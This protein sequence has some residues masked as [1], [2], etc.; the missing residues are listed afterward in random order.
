MS[1][2]NPNRI[3]VTVRDVVLLL[4]SILALASCTE[5]GPTAP[6]VDPVSIE[7]GTL[8]EAIEGRAY[9]QQL[10]A[11]GGGG[12]YDWVVAAGSLPSGLTLSPAGLISGTPVGAGTSSFRVRATDSSGLSATKE[13]AILLVQALA[14]HTWALPDAMEDA[15]YAAQIQ[16]VGGR[17]TLTWSL[18][19]EAAAWLMVSATGSLSGVP[20]AA[21]ASAVTIT[22][23]DESGQQAIRELPILIRGPLAVAAITLPGATEGRAYAAQLVATGGDGAYTWSVESGVLPTGVGLTTGGALTGTPEEGGEFTFTAKVTD[24]A[25]RVATRP[26]SLTVERAPLIQTTLLAPGDVGEPYAAQLV[27]VGGTGAYTWSVT[28]GALPAGLTLSTSG[29]ITGTPTALGSTTFTIRVTDGTGATHT[30]PFTF[31]VAR[32]QELASGVALVG[33]GGEAGSVR[34]YAIRV[35][36]GATRLTVA[37]S[38][39]TGDA[40]LYIR[41]GALPLQFTYDCRPLRQGNEETCTITSPTEGYWYVMLRGHEDF[42]GLSLLA[43]VD[44]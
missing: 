38:G 14:V 1:T 43:R 3:V 5:E 32:T 29:A 8:A 19:G 28:Q 22:V 16:T 7:T 9:S 21:G 34:Y 42:A 18:S 30:R 36:A 23:A 33:I 37:I 6:A 24:G 4:S 20:P 10:T 35:P 26:L 2:F 12:G 39:G 27:A 13:L 44:G 40:D 17:G 11:A 15:E 41:R 25:G 31:V